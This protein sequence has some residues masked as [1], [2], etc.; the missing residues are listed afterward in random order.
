M[1]FQTWEK[2]YSKKR[3]AAQPGIDLRTSPNRNPEVMNKK[4]REKLAVQQASPSTTKTKEVSR[5]R[6]DPS[7]PNMAG[8][9]VN[10]TSNFHLT[11]TGKKMETLHHPKIRFEPTVQHPVSSSLSTNRREGQGTGALAVHDGNA[12]KKVGVFFFFFFLNPEGREKGCARNPQFQ[13]CLSPL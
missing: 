9:H 7:S 2:N 5:S 1:H 10:K 4:S 6:S 13:F 8:G 12:G 11:K 3:E